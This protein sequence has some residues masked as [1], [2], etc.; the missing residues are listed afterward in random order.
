MHHA[1]QTKFLR[2]KLLLQAPALLQQVLQQAPVAK[3]YY[4]QL[5]LK[6]F[7]FSG[8]FSNI[9]LATGFL[10]RKNN[11]RISPTATNELKT[12]RTIF[13]SFKALLSAINASK[14]AC[15]VLLATIRL[16][17]L[18]KVGQTL[19]SLAFKAS[20]RLVNLFCAIKSAS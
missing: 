6:V 13:F 17:D 7:R 11:E 4:V 5:L 8:V 9:F 19:R 14:R 18:S 20:L 2:A 15:M 3:P 1:R 12:I 10:S 16:S